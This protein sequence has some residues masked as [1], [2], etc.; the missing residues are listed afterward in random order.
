MGRDFK[1]LQKYIYVKSPDIVSYAKSKSK[2]RNFKIVK[3][4]FRDKVT[5]CTKKWIE[6]PTKSSGKYII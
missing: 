6:L 4:L 3:Q 1:V 5:I 2:L